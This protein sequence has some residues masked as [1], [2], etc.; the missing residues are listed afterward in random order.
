MSSFKVWYC[1]DCRKVIHKPPHNYEGQRFHS[2]SCRT[3]MQPGE[4]TVSDN[5]TAGADR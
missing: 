4:L 5:V 2:S 3:A 1:P